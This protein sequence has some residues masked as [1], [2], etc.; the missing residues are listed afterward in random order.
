[1]CL[2]I[3]IL[4]KYNKLFLVNDRL[5]KYCREIIE[6]NPKINS[7]KDGLACFVLAKA[8]KTHGV[9]INLV[10]SGYSEDAEMLT[11]SLFD[12]ALLIS[13]CLKD[14]TDKTA[15]NF[16]RFDYPLSWKMFNHLKDK[17]KFK[18]YFEERRNNPKTG[19]EPIEEIQKQANSWINE[20]GKDFYRI[21]HSG[22]TTGELAKSVNLGGYFST[23][24]NL[25]SQLIHSLPRCMNRYLIDDCEKIKMDVSPK[26]SEVSLAIVSAFN[27]LV[28]ILDKFNDHY[29]IIDEKEL[30]QLVDDWVKAVNETTE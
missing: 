20:Y 24:F 28:V 6:F 10:K 5:R 25:Q 17:G 30:K 14:K 29:K 16:F 2:K 9:V 8:Y 3:K 4:H 7:I 15:L 13:S 22:Q 19:D 21:W 18:D 11:R 23:A 1:M 12:L 26:I 27:M